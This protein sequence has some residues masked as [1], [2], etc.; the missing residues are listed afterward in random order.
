MAAKAPHSQVLAH[1]KYPFSPC[2][3]SCL[4]LLR[5]LILQTST[6]LAFKSQD[7]A[8]IMCLYLE[9]AALKSPGGTS[10]R[11]LARLLSLLSRLDGV[12]RKVSSSVGRNFLDT[13][14]DALVQSTSLR[15]SL[16][17]L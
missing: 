15:D 2:S 16:L 3:C 4:H 8:E 13:N 9:L 11:K 5:H 14:I 10:L 7:A 1:C 6:S 12:G 17:L